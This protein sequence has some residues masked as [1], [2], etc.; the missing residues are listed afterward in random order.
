[1]GTAVP[2]HWIAQP[3]A[4]E[5]AQTLH[6]GGGKGARAVAALY[7]RSGVDSRHSVVLDSA[8]NGDSARQSFY[9]PA[10][11]DTDRGPTLAQ[12]MRRYEQEACGLAA[13]AAE[14]ALSA[15]E[16]DAGR[17]THLI[18]ISCTGFSAPG[19]D[20]ELY[21]QL[22]LSPTVART[23]IGFMGCHA[24]L[25]ALR[26][27][28]A[29]TQ[30][31]PTAVVLICT[32]ELCSLHQQYTTDAGQLVS[33]SLFADGAAALVCRAAA[34]ASATR[35]QLQASGSTLVP[36]TLEDMTW[37]LD[38]HG[39]RMSLSARVPE[40][41]RTELPR[42]LTGWLSNQGLS[43]TDVEHWAV[44]PGGPRILTAVEQG[45]ALPSTALVESRLV[46]SRYGNMSSPTVVFILERLNTAR[47]RG[48]CVLLGFGPGLTLEAA[49]LV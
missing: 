12:R 18:T 34:D 11:C 6:A 49:L 14:A 20:I 10:T 23:H 33:N 40:L 22:G 27:A 13:S 37:R 1:M 45:L 38:D 15:A 19:F 21:G 26:V 7:R 44:H 31:D 9:P 3:R 39:F 41:I 17:V 16:I 5:F 4:A 36:N 43:L 47:P 48:P 35:W 8:A 24:M 46:L 2:P 30:Q 25:N 32:V 29:F 42:W 28:S